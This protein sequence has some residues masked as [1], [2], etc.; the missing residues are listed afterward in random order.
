VHQGARPIIAVS[1]PRRWCVAD[2]VTIVIPSAGTVRPPG[3]VSSNGT[4]RSVPTALAPV[5][6]APGPVQVGLEVLDPERAHRHVPA[7]RVQE[8]GVHAAQDVD[9]F[10]L[11]GMADLG[12]HE[13]D[14]GRRPRPGIRITGPG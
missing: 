4:L 7:R 11:D 5:E 8:G 10:G 3:T 9:G 14:P 1:S 13:P 2:T 12:G 6:R